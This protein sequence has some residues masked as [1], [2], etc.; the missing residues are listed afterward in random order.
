MNRPIVREAWELDKGNTMFTRAFIEAME[1][2]PRQELA[3][4][5][6]I[7]EPGSGAK[8]ADTPDGETGHE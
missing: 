1:S 3:G 2:G 4:F 6:G 8:P 5:M 7:D